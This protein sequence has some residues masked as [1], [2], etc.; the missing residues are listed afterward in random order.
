M[1]AAAIS[2]RLALLLPA[3]LIIPAGSKYVAGLAADSVFP[4]PAY[5]AMNV[6][7]APETYRAAAR[8]LARAQDVDGRTVLVRAEAMFASGEVPSLV[9]A[10]AR[11]G[12]ARAPADIR[13]WVLLASARKAHDP[14]GAARIL[15]NALLLGPQEYWVAPRRARLAAD[16]WGHLSDDGKAL[17]ARQVRLL[18]SVPA[19][20][21]HLVSLLATQAGA[22][23]VSES[24]RSNQ[25]E[26]RALNRWIASERRKAQG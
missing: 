22:R 5:M 25:E 17:A 9:E 26:L 6:T 4:V 21:R 18:W 23:L 14:A 10:T 13:G 20:R 24:F 2:A 11:E 3:L 1:Q 12:L 19:L 7:Q 16:L 8:I 15:E